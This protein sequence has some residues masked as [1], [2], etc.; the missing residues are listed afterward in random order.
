M[1]TATEPNQLATLTTQ[2]GIVPDVARPIVEAFQPAFAEV[3]KVLTD[4]ASVAVTDATQRK[5]MQRA[6]DLRMTLVKMRSRV[7]AI[8]VSQK[9]NYLSVTKF[10]DLIARTFREGCEPVEA[11]LED[12]EKFAERAEAARRAKLKAER[13]P[14]LAGLGV[15]PAIYN[16]GDMNDTAWNVLREGLE[17]ANQKRAEEARKAEEARLAAEKAKAEE[18]ARIRA[19]NARIAAELEAE[20]AAARAAAEKAEAERKEAARVAAEAARKAE[21]ERRAAELAARKERE[22][23]EAKAK[24]ERDALE[25]KARAEREAAQKAADERLRVAREE[26]EAKARVERQAAAE[27]ARVASEKAA[28]EARARKAAELAAADLLAACE[29]VMFSGVPDPDGSMLI[30]ASTVQEVKSAIGKAKK[31]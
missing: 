23:I 27:A 31:P 26:A 16:S 3:D 14:I 9:S 25:A 2:S 7:E 15:D 22:A 11:R 1:S 24:A 13:D 29:S 10:I 28:K 6:H 5:E 30:P 12:A 4:A 21:E 8:R 19:E 20:K 18:D 17:L